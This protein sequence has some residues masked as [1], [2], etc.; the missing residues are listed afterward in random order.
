MKGIS[1]EVISV[2]EA[3]AALRCMRLGGFNESEALESIDSLVGRIRKLGTAKLVDDII[4]TDLSENQRIFVQEYWF[5]GKSTAQIARERGMS[6]ANVYRTLTRANETITELLTPL[7]RYHR[8]L[9]DVQ[10]APLFFAEIMGV[11]SARR[12]KGENIGEQLK[13]IRLSRAATPEQTARALC[14]TEKQLGKIEGSVA[15][16]TLELLEKYSA[17]FS[18]RFNFEFVNGRRKCEWKEL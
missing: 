4:E 10:V 3:K 16:P 13:S 18:V 8:D 2:E 5:S 1:D 15:E 17:V 11:C 12:N 9:P 14:I 6:Q 7:V